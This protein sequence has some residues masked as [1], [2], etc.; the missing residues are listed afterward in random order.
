MT[1][2]IWQSFMSILALIQFFGIFPA[3]ADVAP[4]TGD[5][6][7]VVFV[8][9]YKT[10]L[11]RL[12]G[13]Q[14][15]PYGTAQFY[16]PQAI[17]AHSA[18][19][20]FYVLDLPKLLDETTKIWRIAADGTPTLAFQGHST[21]HGG[22]FGKPVS[23]GLDADGCPLVADAVTG[24]WRLEP[25]GHL[26]L[27]FDGK[28]KPLYKISAVTAGP[29][30]DL[31]VGTS[32]LYAVTGGQMLDLPRRLVG[33]PLREYGGSWS[34]SPS[35]GGGSDAIVEL[36]GP[37]VGNSTGRQAPIRVWKN[38]GGLYAVDTTAGQPK[39]QGLV[40]N[41]KPDGAEHDTYW[42]AL[43]QVFVDASG[44][45][46]LVDA[47]SVWK[48]KEDVYIRPDQTPGLK[49]EHPATR[50][51][52]SVINGG[53]FIVHP[54][55]RF[56]ELTFKTPD[57]SSGPMRRPHGAAQWSDDTYLVADPE[58]YVKGIT[59]TGGL[60]LLNLDGSRQARW[61][62]GERLRPLGAAILR[63]AGEP[64]KAATTSPIRLA[65]LAGNRTGGK[66]TLIESVSWECK[67]QDG[68]GLFG[69]VGMNWEVRPKAQAEVRLR[70]IFENSRWSISHDGAM[71]F[72]AGGMN[73]QT[74]GTPLVM[75]GTV[76]QHDGM[77][78]VSARYKTQSMFDTQVGSLDVRIH[79]AGPGAATMSIST[80]I[81]TETE[82]LKA[83]FE[84]IMP[85]GSD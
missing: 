32:Y 3:K 56:E 33:R 65:D 40:A 67:P 39:I 44:R 52:T 13:Q 47:G 77:L 18:D 81:F 25:N 74:P 1:N 38:Q 54:D 64:A 31:I 48:R 49:P 6:D 62:F 37:G 27:L 57:E 55:G 23:L 60:L 58:M 5:R 84:Q 9:R 28:D 22:P 72:S 11:Y 8:A 51:T 20:C 76:T 79:G 14:P 12:V 59:G 17:V 36:T 45:I 24:L 75:T 2:R 42:R 4:P 69:S 53:V 16:N 73:P 30:R 15:R 85:L 26:Q 63:D 10:N 34:P 50:T 46:V 61:P 7:L 70:S 78:S 80:N 71:D 35:Y 43:N 21:T 82:R 41:R 83:T 19:K 68:G 66:I 29:K